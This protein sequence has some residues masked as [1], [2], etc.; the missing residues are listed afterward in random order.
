MRPWV[1]R[2]AEPTAQ[3]RAVRTSRGIQLPSFSKTTG[4]GTLA[5]A[6][7]AVYIDR[8]LRESEDRYSPF[9]DIVAASAM[10]EAADKK[11]V[12]GLALLAGFKKGYQFAR[13]RSGY[14]P[15]RAKRFA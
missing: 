8:F 15:T 14:P 9:I 7:A 11:R 3:V 10:D 13:K 4:V 12:E 2:S 5:S 6:E 1:S